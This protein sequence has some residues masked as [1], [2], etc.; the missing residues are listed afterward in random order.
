[1]NGLL[2][3]INSPVDLKRLKI[4]QL[5]QLASEIREEMIRVV[6]R[7]GGHLAS[8]LGAVELAIALH[9]VFNSPKDTIIWD[10][11]HQAYAHKLL[12]GRKER[13]D[14]LR[15]FG[16][17]SGF[18]NKDESSHDPF[19]VGHAS[20]SI[21]QALGMVVANSLTRSSGRVVAVIGD[22]A[23]TGG[24][25]FEALNHAGQLGKKIIVVL[26]SNEMAISPSVGALSKYLNKIITNPLYNRIRQDI[27]TLVK[28]IPKL[29]PK[30]L[31]TAQRLEES[32]KDLLVPGAFFE[33]LGF[34]YFGPI[35]G[36]NL[37]LV[38]QALKNI[39]LINEPVLL[40]LITK[41]GKGY[42]F[43]ESDPVRFHSAA[44]FDVET[45]ISKKS[46]S[47]G[48]NFTETFGRTVCDLASRDKRIVVITPAMTAGTG[49]V[50][51]AKA[52]PTRLFDVGIAEQHALTFAGG[53]ARGGLKPAVAI[54]STF[55]QRAYDQMV[56]DIC[57]QNLDVVFA[58]DRAGLVGE[59]GP[60][61]HGVFDIAYLGHIPNLVLMAPKDEQELKDM[62]YTAVSLPG[63][64]AI[65]YP[66]RGTGRIQTDKDY[67]NIQLGQAE[68]L[69]QGNGPV[70]MAIGS[71]V[72]PA[73][74]AAE[75]LA[76]ED[77]EPTVVNARFVRP[78]DEVL[79]DELLANGNRPLVT[80][81]EHVERCGFGS[82]V[83]EFLAERG[84]KDI[85]IKRL[86]LP[87]SFIEQGSRGLL[88]DKYG[89]SAEGIA[90]SVREVI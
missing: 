36:H 22:G 72:Y 45:G 82:I 54:Y 18:P 83:L 27:R 85:K 88:L 21:S 3:S 48:P 77:I 6:S 25:A 12:T 60:T 50:E 13:F 62:I 61:H 14:S 26:N 89:L 59:D 10:V 19:T 8:S 69:K 37:A 79:L 66:K 46:Q 63:P 71:M 29:G 57:L 73:L 68:V 5:P 11:G 42:K 81:E 33:E 7:T 55:L 2:D 15:Q 52:F 90:D 17:I 78:L 67:H 65:R 70:I 1:M 24:M 20:T 9:Y 35:D 16:G 44:P 38:I 47:A 84:K 86:A 30:M 41:K 23:L 75:I 49:L 39:S 34:R 32:L 64:V 51:F 74:Q 53:L 56:H 4:R 31:T 43:A 28:R 87:N 76:K 80:V 58:I 40:H